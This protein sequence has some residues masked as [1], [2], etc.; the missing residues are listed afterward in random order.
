[1]RLVYACMVTYVYEHV[2]VY[3]HTYVRNDCV[4]VMLKY[5]NELSFYYLATGTQENAAVRT[6]THM[7]TCTH[8][9][10]YACIYLHR[11]AMNWTLYV[12]SIPVQ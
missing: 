12:I 5:L 3:V 4:M 7:H 1:M 8:T 9:N 2:H 10:A 11:H 6:R